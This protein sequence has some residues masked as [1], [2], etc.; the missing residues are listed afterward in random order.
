MTGE[1][2]EC[3]LHLVIDACHKHHLALEENDGNTTRAAKALGVAR[4]TLYRRLKSK[5]VG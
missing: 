2:E 4:A 3:F 1:E 5:K